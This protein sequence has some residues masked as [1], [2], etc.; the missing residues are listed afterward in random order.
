M[1]NII[2]IIISQ[3]TC[4]SLEM[5]THVARVLA[6]GP[7]SRETSGGA[8]LRF[9]CEMASERGCLWCLCLSNC[10]PVQQGSREVVFFVVVVV[11][12]GD[13]DC[14]SCLC[15]RDQR[16][17]RRVAKYHDIPQ[18]Q[19]SPAGLASVWLSL[20][21]IRCCCTQVSI[22]G[23]RLDAREMSILVRMMSVGRA[24]REGGAK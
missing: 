23:A 10:S 17:A 24:S 4:H 8:F 9:Q 19:T 13:G 2:I 21:D 3:I 5:I 14:P 16:P 15:E 20:A 22:H 1:I 18:T 7:S 11:V 12:V 6:A